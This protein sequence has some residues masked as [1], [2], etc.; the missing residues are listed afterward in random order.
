MS[1]FV[2]QAHLIG[3]TAHQSVAMAQQRAHGADVFRGP[4][5]APQQTDRVEIL[6]PLAILDVGLAAGQIFTMAGVDQADFQTGGFEDL[7]E[8]NPIDAGGLHGHGLDAAS[9]Q[10]VAQLE[11]ILGEGIKAAH[12][13]GIAAG[14]DG[15]P[16][17]TGADVNAGGVKMK[18]GELRVN[19]LLG[20]LVA[21]G[22]RL[23]FVNGERRADGPQRR[24]SKWSNLLSGMH[25]D[26]STS[27]AHQ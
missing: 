19:F 25:R 8:G 14:R 18:C 21:R 27:R 23:P 17:F 6:E 5:A 13:F 1:A 10:P 4:E 24:N 15:H 16:D 9:Q 26:A 22:H 20:L 7:I 12:R 2:H 11:Q 3:G